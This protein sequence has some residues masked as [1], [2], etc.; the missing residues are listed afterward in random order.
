MKKSQSV[1]NLDSKSKITRR[2][3]DET[4]K[5]N[6]DE[7]I[8]NRKFQRKLDQLSQL[9]TKEMNFQKR[10]LNL[11]RFEI[12]TFPEVNVNDIEHVHKNNLMVKMKNG[13][14]ILNYK[15]D[16]QQKKNEESINKQRKLEKEK[17]KA[18]MKLIKSLDGKAFREFTRLG[19]KA[20]EPKLKQREDF[21]LKKNNQNDFMK[22][23]MDS[24]E[25]MNKIDKDLSFY[26]FVEKENTK[27]INPSKFKEKKYIP[28]KPIVENVLP[29]KPMEHFIKLEQPSK[30]S[31]KTNTFFVRKGHHHSSEEHN[32]K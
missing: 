17:E 14:K 24:N 20:S 19:R 10:I 31:S 5:Y 12:H 2:D 18:E 13:T 28:R 32:I 6:Y 22:L 15:D 25:I 23:I 30:F 11:K 21:A 7:Y 1:I 4:E 9:S 29:H 26:E 3:L 27:A 8:S 16:I